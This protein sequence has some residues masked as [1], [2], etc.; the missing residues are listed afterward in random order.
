MTEKK[1][2]W[3]DYDVDVQLTGTRT[4]RIG[5]RNAMEALEK[6]E[7]TLELDCGIILYCEAVCLRKV[8]G[9]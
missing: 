4:I 7:M 9:A 5:A 1:S 6:A 2:A 8:K 3:K